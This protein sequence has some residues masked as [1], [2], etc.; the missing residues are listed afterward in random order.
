M[1]LFAKIRVTT[2]QD[3]LGIYETIDDLL[4][5]VDRETTIAA[6]TCPMPSSPV[7]KQLFILS[8]KVAITT[9]TMNPGLKTVR[10]NVT[11]M[12]ADSVV[13][14]VFGAVSN[15]WCMFINPTAV[16]GA[17]SWGNIGGTLAN[18]TDLQNAL[19]AKLATNGNGSALTGITSSQI[20]GYAGYVINVQAL[21]SSPGD[22]ATSY[23]G[24]L[25]KAPITTPAVSKVYIRQAGTIKRAEIYC[26]SGTAG[27]AEAWPI[28]IRLNN[29]T[30]TLIASLSVS[31]Q[32]RVYSNTNLNIA[33]VAGDYFEI[34]MVNPTWGTNP[35]TTIFGGYIYIE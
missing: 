21:T 32:E 31:A 33:V 12:Q 11:S 24:T 29:T 8:T 4:V 10:G 1:D 26:F 35:L 19:N 5:I 13:G 34:K 23:F 9:L 30:D 18:Q 28:S 22:G 3:L 16:A 15:A 2:A 27:T 20:S 17:T 6:G 14:W 25:P 7:D